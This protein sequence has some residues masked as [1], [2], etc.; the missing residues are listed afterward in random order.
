MVPYV[1]LIVVAG[2]ELPREI[3]FYDRIVKWASMALVNERRGRGPAVGRANVLVRKLPSPVCQH[4]MAF[5]GAL[6]C[7]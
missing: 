7:C 6:V 4:N 1:E 5:S 2:E 3:T